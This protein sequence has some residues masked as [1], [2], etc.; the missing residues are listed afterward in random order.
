MKR[1]MGRLPNATGRTRSRGL[2]SNASISA[3]VSR[4]PAN[5]RSRVDQDPFHPT[6]VQQVVQ[7]ALCPPVGLEGL[8]SDLNCPRPVA[9]QLRQESFERGEIL[10]AKCSRQLH[11]QRTEAARQRRQPLHELPH[12]LIGVA[13][14]PVVGDRTRQ[15]EA[16]FEALR[17]LL[18]PTCDR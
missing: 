4:G 18:E 1:T 9:R 13:E 6:A 3:A 10:W 8:V 11:P 15:L 14:S 16:E 17:C 5:T 12:Q 2:R 7:L